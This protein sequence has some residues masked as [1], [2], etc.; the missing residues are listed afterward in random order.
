MLVTLT[1]AWNVESLR[2][3]LSGKSSAAAPSGMAF[4]FSTSSLLTFDAKNRMMP[5]DSGVT[6]FRHFLYSQLKKAVAKELAVSFRSL[7]SSALHESINIAAESS[8]KVVFK[9]VI[10]YY[11]LIKHFKY[12]AKVGKKTWLS[13][14]FLIILCKITI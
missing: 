9:F 7:S 12:K 10:I 6:L 13:Q 1:T 3:L 8:I 2:S 14:Y 4:S 5:C 11:K